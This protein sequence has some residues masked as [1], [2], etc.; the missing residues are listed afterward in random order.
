MFE[1]LVAFRYLRSQRR[2][3]AIFSTALISVIGVGVGVFSLNIVLSVMSGFQTEL[4]KTILGASPHILVSS[5]DGGVENRAEIENKI[6]A[7]PGVSGVSPVIYGTGLLVSASGS[8]G[9][10]VSAINP[11]AHVK[12]FPYL[13]SGRG[14]QTKDGRSVFSVLEGFSSP[15]PV[16]IGHTLAAALGVEEGGTVTFAASADSKNP[17]KRKPRTQEFTV[18][19]IFKYGMAY[20]DSTTSYMNIREA[21]DFFGKNTAVSFEVAV[22]NPMASEQ[23]ARSIEDNLGFPFVAQSWQEA[24]SKLFAALSLEKLGLTV[25]LGF[26]VLVAALSVMSVLLMMMIEKSRDISILRAAGAST[27]QIGNIFVIIG[28]TLGFAG[29]FTGSVLALG[30]CYLLETSA[31]VSGLIPFD[32][33]VYGISKFPVI[34]EP[35]HFLV[36][37]AISQSLCVLA[38]LY[39]ARSVRSGSIASKLKVQ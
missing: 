18:A 22:A 36:V 23:T 28:A 27:K 12:T 2:V 38:A 24:N 10:T 7:T 25:F 6:S 30:V 39:P 20:Y 32:P 26:I 3:R 33:D 16:V 34:I 17:F 4:Q 13:L 8:Q 29:T 15:P 21:V 11:E 14:K 1:L 37:G 5:Y 9:T 31:T 19:G 35:L